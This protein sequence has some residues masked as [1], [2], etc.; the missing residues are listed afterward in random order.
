[1]NVIN[2]A[3]LLKLKEK[4]QSSLLTMPHYH[5]IQIIM[6]EWVEEDATLALKYAKLTLEAVNQ[7]LQTSELT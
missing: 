2:M 7:Y 5:A 6:N 4:L 1:M 3:L